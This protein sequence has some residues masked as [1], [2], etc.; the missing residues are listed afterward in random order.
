MTVNPFASLR[1]MSTAAAIFAALVLLFAL[2]A[3]MEGLG[4]RMI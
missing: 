2:L 3:V 4:N 1:R